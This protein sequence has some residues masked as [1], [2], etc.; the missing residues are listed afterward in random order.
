MDVIWLCKKKE[1]E[2]KPKEEKKAKKQPK[3][4][5]TVTPNGI[6]GSFLQE[7]RRPLIAHL[8]INS[9]NIIFQLGEG[10]DPRPPGQPEPYDEGSE[11]VFQN[12]SICQIY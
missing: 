6:E 4:I 10:Y 7:P 3:I 2:D 5:A 11:N 12:Q 9:G 8:P 1:K